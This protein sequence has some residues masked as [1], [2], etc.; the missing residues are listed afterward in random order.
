MV[1]SGFY[2]E[3]VIAE[4]LGVPISYYTTST[5]GLPALLGGLTGKDL[6]KC[7]IIGKSKKKKKLRVS[8]AYNRIGGTE[9]PIVCLF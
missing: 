8:I 3:P 6:Y 5:H 2:L 9:F 7:I 1:L 4:K